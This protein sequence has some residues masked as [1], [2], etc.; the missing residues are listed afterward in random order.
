MITKNFAPLFSQ[1]YGKLLTVFDTI[2]SLLNAS[3]FDRNALKLIYDYYCDRSQKTKV[4]SLF[5]AYLDMIYGIPQ[6]PLLGPLLF[7]IDLF[8]LFFEDYIV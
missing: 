2:F 7:N 3:R 8:D 5:S 4:G 1:I 6:G